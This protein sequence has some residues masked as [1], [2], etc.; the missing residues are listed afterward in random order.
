MKKRIKGKFSSEQFI[1]NRKKKKKKKKKKIKRIASKKKETFVFLFWS[2]S[3]CGFFFC[4]PIYLH[5]AY[6]LSIV[7]FVFCLFDDAIL[8]LQEKDNETSSKKKNLFSGKQTLDAREANKR[9]TFHL[10]DTEGKKSDQL[11]QRLI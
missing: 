10:L 4:S 7:S 3:L 11:L 1:N 6:A 5:P 2:F 8:F 9:P